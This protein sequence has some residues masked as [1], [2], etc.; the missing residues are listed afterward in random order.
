MRNEWVSP[1]LR[2]RLHLIMQPCKIDFQSQ[3]RVV[4]KSDH[5]VM[6]MTA[7]LCID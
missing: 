1:S 7:L 4:L 5:I 6:L 2:T 3:Y